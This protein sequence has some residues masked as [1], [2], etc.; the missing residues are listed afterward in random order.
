MDINKNSKLIIVIG[1]NPDPAPKGVLFHNTMAWLKGS[2]NTAWGS[3]LRKG[4]Y[5]QI[6]IGLT[7]Q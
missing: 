6:T 7:T 1:R 2:K 4:A 3:A 5:I